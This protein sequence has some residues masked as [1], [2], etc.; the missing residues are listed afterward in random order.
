MKVGYIALGGYTSTA[1]LD[2]DSRL[3][4]FYTGVDKY[5]DNPVK[6][7]WNDD[8]EVRSWVEVPL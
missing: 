3:G 7:Y 8:D 4:E 2:E 6:V 1:Y 5:T